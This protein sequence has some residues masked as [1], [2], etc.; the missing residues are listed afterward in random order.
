MVENRE[1]REFLRSCT[2]NSILAVLS[3]GGG[4]LLAKTTQ[5][6]RNPHVCISRGIC[7]GCPVYPDCILPQA[8]SA[9]KAKMKKRSGIRRPGGTTSASRGEA[10]TR[11]VHG[12]DRDGLS[13]GAI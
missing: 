7:G 8:S 13:S 4:A 12:L 2:R 3:I 1:R 10:E 6:K 5:A 9:R 11:L